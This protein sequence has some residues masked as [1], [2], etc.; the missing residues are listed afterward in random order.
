M[1]Y[2]RN[3]KI[4]RGQI[5]AAPFAGLFFLLVLMLFIFSTH[6][7]VPGVRVTVE[8]REPA[9]ELPDRTLSLR[10]EGIGYQGEEHTL[11]SFERTLRQQAKVGEVPRRLNY[12][13]DPKVPA[14]MREKVQTLALE[15]GIELRAPGNRLELPEGVGFPGTP[16]PVVVVGI[17]L[18][19]QIFYQH[20]AIRPE[21]LKGKLEALRR[22][23]GAVSVV[24]Q[25]DRHVRLEEVMEVVQ[26]AGSAGID[27]VT[28]GTRPSP[29]Q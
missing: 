28:I 7:F 3:A 29:R 6:V 14:E 4:F 10:P 20:Q 13:V 8:D 17:N 22:D 15:L 16:G 5:D 19:G 26:I 27:E 18:N 23:E 9:P 1:R 25:A 24:V 21:M 2:P 11:E 12:Q